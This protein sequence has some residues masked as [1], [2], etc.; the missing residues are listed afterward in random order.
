M[1]PLTGIGLR[2]LS[3]DDPAYRP[4]Y[5]GSPSERDGAYHQGT[6]WSWLLGPYVTALVRFSGRSGLMKAERVLAQMKSHLQ[7]SCVGSVSEVFDAE[8]PFTPRGA[9]AQAWSVGELL[10]VLC[11]DVK[12]SLPSGICMSGEHRERT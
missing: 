3:P 8:P 10:R 1:L 4:R 7:E 6:V 5:G 11:G 2:S 9:I 12:G